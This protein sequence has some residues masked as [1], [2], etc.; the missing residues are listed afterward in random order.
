M[1]VTQEFIDSLM[2]QNQRLSEQVDLFNKTIAEI[3]AII[4]ELCEQ[5]NKKSGNSSKS[6]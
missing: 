5:I 4:K 1:P 6:P 3:N 2:K